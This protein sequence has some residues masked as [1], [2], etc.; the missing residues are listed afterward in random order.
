M[1]AGRDGKANRRAAVH[2]RRRDGRCNGPRATRGQHGQSDAPRRL[3][4]LER[5][6]VERVAAYRGVER[7][8]WV[9]RHATADGPWGPFATSARPSPDAGP[10]AAHRRCGH[11]RNSREHRRRLA[12]RLIALHHR[13]DGEGARG[14][15]G[16]LKIREPHG[17]VAPL[18]AELRRIARHARAHLEL[19]GGLPRSRVPAGPARRTRVRNGRHAPVTADRMGTEAGLPAARIDRAARNAFPARSRPVSTPRW[20]T[21]RRFHALA[22]PR[23]GSPERIGTPPGQAKGGR[24]VVVLKAEREALRGRWVERGADAAGLRARAPLLCGQ[25]R[26]RHRRAQSLRRDRRGRGACASGPPDCRGTTRRGGCSRPRSRRSPAARPDR[27]P[28][29]HHRR[30]RRSRGLPGRAERP[31]S[32]RLPPNAS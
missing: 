2:V 19:E 23:R 20:R 8:A 4:C 6:G 26:R 24:W 12:G 3:R 10:E 15:D 28:S 14:R 25:R 31:R 1:F 18:V 27:G 13:Y 5:Q 30:Q 21:D 11:C 16:H 9:Q 17:A 7:H 29:A 22:P 32:R